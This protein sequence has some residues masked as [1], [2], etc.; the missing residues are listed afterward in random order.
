MNAATETAPTTETAPEL[1]I[2]DTRDN[3]RIEF[4][5]EELA[6]CMWEAGASTTRTFAAASRPGSSRS[7]S[8]K[9]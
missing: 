1:T 4:S 6:E 5:A 8:T 9:P 7:P 2:I 3:E